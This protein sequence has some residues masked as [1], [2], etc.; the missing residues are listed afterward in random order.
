MP[1]GPAPFLSIWKVE[2]AR[3]RERGRAG[4]AQGGETSGIECAVQSG[5][6]AGPGSR[7]QPGEGAS[8][9]VDAMSVAPRRVLVPHSCAGIDGQTEE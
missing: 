1:G 8:V 2:A 6:A 7:R 9:L 5:R 3:V 4:G